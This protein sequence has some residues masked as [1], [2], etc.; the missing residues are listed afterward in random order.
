M[1]QNWQGLER[2]EGGNGRETRLATVRFERWYIYPL[3][4]RL[5]SGPASL[6][7]QLVSSITHAQTAALT[8]SIYDHFSL[9]FFFEAAMN[10]IPLELF[11]E[12]IGY[13]DDKESLENC[14]LVAK[15]WEDPSRKRLFKYIQTPPGSLET[16]LERISQGRN[17]TLLEHV[18]RLTCND[19]FSWTL[20]Y[21]DQPES[22]DAFRGHYR[23]LRRLR[24]LKLCTADID[25]SLQVTESVFSVFRNTLSCITLLSCGVS[26]SLI[27]T[28]V[29][30]LPNLQYL[31]L[32]DVDFIDSDS[33]EESTLSISRSPLKRLSIGEQSVESLGFLSRLWELELRFDEIILLPSFIHFSA[34]AEVANYVICTFGTSAKCLRIPNIS[35]STCSLLY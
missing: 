7:Q 2:V 24:H 33:D 5:H 1:H 25:T 19:E 6:R 17:G 14:S 29:N 35:N 21:P 9:F 26:K 18:Y 12:I 13:I 4:V 23:S 27:P 28:L 8:F 11:Y 10:S 3:V 16:W 20:L 22:H 32:K 34:W 30:C 31:C 15:S